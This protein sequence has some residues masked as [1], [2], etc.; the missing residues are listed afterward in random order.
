M[1]Q[2]AAVVR[3]AFSDILS[4][5]DVDNDVDGLTAMLRG[6]HA[7][8]AALVAVMPHHFSAATR[9]CAHI[10][11]EQR[12][13]ISSEIDFLQVPTVLLLLGMLIGYQVFLCTAFLGKDDVLGRDNCTL[14]ALHCMLCM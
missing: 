9:Q 5:P 7:C 14:M 10:F 11:V 12:K 6:L 3:A 2:E 4:G 1:A 8:A 13:V